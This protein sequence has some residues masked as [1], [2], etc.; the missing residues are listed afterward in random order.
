MIVVD[1]NV[2]AFIILLWKYAGVQFR[3]FLFILT[4]KPRLVWDTWNL[5][6]TIK[7]KKGDWADREAEKILKDLD[8]DQNQ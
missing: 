8:M 1:A 3:R 6:R 4:F 2:G 7:G 5:K